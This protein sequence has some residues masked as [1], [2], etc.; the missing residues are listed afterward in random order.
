MARRNNR[1]I[2]PEARKALDNFKLEVAN[3]LELQ[4]MIKLIKGT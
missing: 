1:V 4:T 3:E 2:V